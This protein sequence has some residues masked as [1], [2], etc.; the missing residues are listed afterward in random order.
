MLRFMT[1]GAVFLSLVLTP[2]GVGS[3]QGWMSQFV[4]VVREYSYKPVPEV[5]LRDGD[6]RRII[7]YLDAGCRIVSPRKSPLDF[8]RGLVQE[9][10]LEGPVLFRPGIVYIKIRFFGR[11]TAGEFHEAMK[12]L[13]QRPLTGLIVDVRSNKGGLL[14]TTRTLIERWIDAGK[15]Y[16]TLEQRGSRISAWVSSNPS[17]ITLPTV[18]L[19]NAQ[20]A[21]CSELFAASLQSA[22]KAK[23]VGTNTYGKQF[24]QEVF[25][26]DPQ[27]VLFLT[28]AKVL[29][30][31]AGSDFSG[32]L[33]DVLV[34][35][36]TAQLKTALMLLRTRGTGP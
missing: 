23:I 5:L 17:P 20:T 2:A 36:E 31:N 25:P 3:E 26:L 33:P 24:V 35:D 9:G 1:L 13:A 14:G 28:T 10:S 7:E 18:V 19:V 30:G 29:A 16:L 22:K 34:T 15:G 27:H 11:R 21:S 6:T 4:Q 8:V 12:K 32:V